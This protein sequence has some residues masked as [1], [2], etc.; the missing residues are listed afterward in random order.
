MSQRLRAFLAAATLYLASIANISSANEVND[1]NN[2]HR[3]HEIAT[4]LEVSV[5]GLPAEGTN[6]APPSLVFGNSHDSTT[7]GVESAV[8][9]RKLR[10]EVAELYK[11]KNASD[12]KI[13]ELTRKVTAAKQ[14]AE[15]RLNSQRAISEKLAKLDTEYKE[16]KEEHMKI[17]KEWFQ[18]KYESPERKITED[19]K[20]LQ[21]LRE[22]HEKAVREL[23]DVRQKLQ[24][25]KTSSTILERKRCK[26]AMTELEQVKKELQTLKEGKN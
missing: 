26:E 6:G 8:E 19:E 20:E 13:V 18:L 15:V 24:V 3:T 2:N 4:T 1:Q 17:K 25:A 10:S 12:A 5:D 16:F 7:K 21:E 22:E 23:R 11:Q 9:I 14:E